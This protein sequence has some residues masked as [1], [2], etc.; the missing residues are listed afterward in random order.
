MDYRRLLR[1]DEAHAGCNAQ[2]TWRDCYDDESKACV[3]QELLAEVYRLRRLLGCEYEAGYSEG[4][5]SARADV[6]ALVDG[7]YDDVE[8]LRLVRE[9]LVPSLRRHPDTP[10]GG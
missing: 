10:T 6:M 1:I 9:M 7:D 2:Q 5:S 4:E 3:V 8:A